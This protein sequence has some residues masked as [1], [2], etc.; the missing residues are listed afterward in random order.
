MKTT[1]KMD[2][3]STKFNQTIIITKKQLAS[4][5]SASYLD[6]FKSVKH[7]KVSHQITTDHQ[8]NRQATDNL[9]K[10]RF[11]KQVNQLNSERDLKSSS[12]ALS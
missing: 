12:Q 7:D 10:S 8:Q 3:K 5:R 4:Q 6:Q 1:N 11:P 9:S 2:R